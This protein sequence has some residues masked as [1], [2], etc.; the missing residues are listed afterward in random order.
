MKGTA[1]HCS[2]EVRREGTDREPEDV[3]A[4]DKGAAEY[5]C[6]ALQWFQLQVQGII[7]IL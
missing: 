3:R 2:Q 5:L 1:Q 4:E 7:P 6:G